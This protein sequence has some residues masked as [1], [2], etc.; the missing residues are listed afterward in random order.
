MSSGVPSRPSS[1]LDFR[2][3]SSSKLT[4]CCLVQPAMVIETIGLS[5]GSSVTATHETARIF[6]MSV[7]V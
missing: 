4:S 6:M 5:S 2:S 1:F 7:F 3:K